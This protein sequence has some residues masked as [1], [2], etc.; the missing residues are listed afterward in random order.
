[1]YK[2][3]KKIFFC[4]ICDSRQ[5]QRKEALRKILGLIM[6]TSFSSALEDMTTRIC[7]RNAQEFFPP[8]VCVCMM[9]NDHF[10]LYAKSIENFFVSDSHK[11]DG[12]ETWRADAC[13]GLEATRCLNSLV[14]ST[15]DFWCNKSA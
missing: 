6:Q 5:K 10:H 3:Q 4:L 13:R 11:I 15:K 7:E 1:M 12:I 8:L 14:R 9:I 2:T